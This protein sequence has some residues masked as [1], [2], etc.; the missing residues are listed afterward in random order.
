MK[1]IKIWD[2]KSSSLF[3]FFSKRQANKFIQSCE[4]NKIKWRWCNLHWQ[5]FF[6]GYVNL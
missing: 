3:F 4:F 2:D 5:G 6:K 1:F